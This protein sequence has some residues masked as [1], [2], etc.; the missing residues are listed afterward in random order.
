M[1][2]IFFA[3]KAD[4]DDIIGVQPIN[5]GAPREFHRV[6]YRTD[7]VGMRQIRID[8]F[9]KV[10]QNLEAAGALET[11]N[12]LLLMWDASEDAAKA[13]PIADI[14]AL[15]AGSSLGAHQY[16]AADAA[17]ATQARDDTG[18]IT[19]EVVTTADGTF[20]LAWRTPFALT[21]DSVDLATRAGTCDVQ[22]RDDG[23]AVTGFGTAVSID[24]NNSNT[25][26]DDAV[27][28]GSQIDMVITNAASLTGVRFAINFT[29]TA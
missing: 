21:I 13:V 12:D 23:A 10:I 18:T 1:T 25:L 19:G 9:F 22:I 24:G 7:T 26:V 16:L 28:A 4:V 2:E 3:N 15:G 20:T 5:I 29:R 27:V 6:L 14:A 17:A 8:N 11:A